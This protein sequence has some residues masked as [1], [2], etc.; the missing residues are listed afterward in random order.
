MCLREAQEG[1]DSERSKN[2]T[3][4]GQAESTVEGLRSEVAGV[5]KDLQDALELCNEH[6]A[7]I[8]ERNHELA[9]CDAEIRSGR[10]E[11]SEK[12]R[13]KEGGGYRGACSRKGGTEGGREIWR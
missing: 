3:E 5:K 4:L 1:L 9:S 2:E 7:L 11:G 6:E 8:E 10:W 12:G 13:E